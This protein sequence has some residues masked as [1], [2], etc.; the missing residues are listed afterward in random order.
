MI[1]ELAVAD[2]G[3]R[4]HEETERV[5]EGVHAPVAEAQAGGALV[6]DDDGVT[7]G[8]EGVFPDQAVVAQRFDV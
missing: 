6:L 8:I 7:H 5:H 3:G 4:K 1:A 2:A